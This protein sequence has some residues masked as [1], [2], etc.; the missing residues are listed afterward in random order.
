M[1]LMRWDGCDG[2]D[3]M[4]HSEMR[5]DGWMSRTGMRWDGRSAPHRAAAAGADCP[6]AAERGRREEE[7]EEEVRCK[8]ARPL[9]QP[10]LAAR[11][12]P[13]VG[14]RLRGG[15]AALLPRQEGGEGAGV[16]AG[17]RVRG[18]GSGHCRGGAGAEPLGLGV[19]G[20]GRG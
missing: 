16:S 7:E 20:R 2:M 5:W 3:A 14:A 19:P 10:L 9:G 12:A 18:S 6:P 15:G 1:G 17:V 11:P 4:D 8:R 13:A